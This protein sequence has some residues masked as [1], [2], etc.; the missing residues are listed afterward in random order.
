MNPNSIGK[1]TELCNELKCFH[2]KDHYFICLF[3][4]AVLGISSVPGTHC[5]KT[6]NTQ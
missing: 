6:N 3:I 5:A 2:P 4:S 1:C